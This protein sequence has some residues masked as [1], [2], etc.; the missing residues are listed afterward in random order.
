[1]DP[2]WTVWLAR[3]SATAFRGLAPELAATRIHSLPGTYWEVVRDSG[4]APCLVVDD[5]TTASLAELRV[6]STPDGSVDGGFDR[7]VLLMADGFRACN[8]EGRFVTCMSWALPRAPEIRALRRA[9][10][11]KPAFS[12]ESMVV[13]LHELAHHA[14][15]RDDAALVRWRELARV[16]LDK[17]IAAL[18]DGPMKA[19]LVAK[20]VAFGLDPR[21]AEEQV[22]AY[23]ERLRTRD[24]IREELCCDLLA[25]VGFVNLESGADVL[26]EEGP[27]G[28]GTREVG[29][30][31]FVA[32][33]T[34]QNIQLLTAAR[35]VAER[36][37]GGS[38]G[39]FAVAALTMEL[40][41]RS[42]GLVFLLS[43]ILRAWCANGSLTDDLARAIRDGHPAF[44]RSV[45]ARNAARDRTLLG[46]LE[47][48]DGI[49][50]D[51]ERY[52]EFAAQGR[53]R[54][55]EAG[56]A[57]PGDLAEMDA[58]RWRLTLA[59]DDQPAA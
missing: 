8:D 26:R 39:S 30:A 3:T 48:L 12:A 37:S 40:T 29:D 1:M 16:A 20:G 18:E 13:L 2:R 10:L 19:Q 17:L 43:N 45:A 6:L 9:S 56:L 5:E 4:G 25:S 44:L 52:L 27:S 23:V 22:T 55:R 54:M 7:G 59:D 34:I 33:S 51:D 11:A 53:A 14:L 31:L 57:E 47:E 50:L 24:A 38:T 49:L 42:S 32:H 46:P 41:A 35:E 15:R 58:A 28:L 21:A 36:I